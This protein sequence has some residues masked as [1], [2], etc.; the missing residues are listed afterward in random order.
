MQKVLIIGAGRSATSLIK[1]L[2]EGAKTRSWFITVADFNL[3]AAQSKIQKTSKST[4]LQLDINNDADRQKAIGDHDIIIS[5][6]PARMHGIVAKDCLAFGKHMIT[7]SYVSEEIKALHNDFSEKGI[8]FMGEMGLDPGIDHMSAMEKINEIKAAGGT[9]NSFRSYT[10]GII[11]PESDDNPWHYKFTWNPRNVVLAGQ[12]TAK[13]LVDGKYTYAPYRRLFETAELVDIKG[14]GDFE[15]YANRDSLGYQTIYGLQDSPNILRGT[16]RHPGFCKAWN[17]LVALGLTDDTYKINNSES[18]SYHDW[19]E[20][21]VRHVQGK[22]AAEKVA[23][24]VG[25]EVNGTVMEQIKWLD[26]FSDQKIGLVAASPA[27][28]LQKLLMQKW[29]LKPTDKD[30]IIMQHEFEYVLNGEEKKLFSTMHMK[31]ENATDTAMAK[32][33]GL[34]LGIFTRL[35]LEGKVSLT[36]VQIPVIKSV[37]SQVLKEL[38]AF[39]VKFNETILTTVS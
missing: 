16:L 28:I 18:L 19:V 7:A 9:I 6:L 23:N 8:L 17:V 12:S 26:L 11:A 21:Y 36:G 22:T 2:L 30:W 39:D 15:M 25:L 24:L 3:N 31:G 14:I 38:E 29:T 35:I 5:M 33:V 4:A 27:Q 10:G 20:A 1:Y 32:L 13:Y 37:Y 34:P